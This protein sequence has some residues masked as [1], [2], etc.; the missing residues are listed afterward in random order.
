[1][2]GDGGE[3]AVAEEVEGVV[4]VTIDRTSQLIINNNMY[5]RGIHH[6]LI[7]MS[8]IAYNIYRHSI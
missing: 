3:V 6:E 1:M 7:T 4:E 5:N 8:C 2:D